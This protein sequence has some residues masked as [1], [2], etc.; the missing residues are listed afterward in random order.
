M[1]YRLNRVSLCDYH[2]SGLGFVVLLRHYFFPPLSPLPSS[3]LSPFPPP[4]ILSIL[5]DP[6]RSFL[7]LSFTTF[8]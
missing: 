2:G 7:P 8:Q 1:V 4:E 3:P 6:F 5:F